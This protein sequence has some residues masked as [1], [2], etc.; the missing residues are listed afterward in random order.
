[1]AMRL[2]KNAPLS[3][4]RVPEGGI[5][6]G[7]SPH[8]QPAFIAPI[9]ARARRNERNVKGVTSARRLRQCCQLRGGENG[10]ARG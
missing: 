5:S 2:L 4:D 9:V 7:G 1:M 8:S 10:I 6:D 3:R